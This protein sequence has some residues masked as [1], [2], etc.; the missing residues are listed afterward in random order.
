MIC[1]VQKEAMRN[2]EKIP[3]D[4]ISYHCSQLFS[5]S[6]STPDVE[7]SQGAYDTSSNSVLAPEHENPQSKPIIRKQD[8]RVTGR[9]VN[10]NRMRLPKPMREP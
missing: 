8:K 3:G 10:R 9:Y 2:H 7:E 6:E 5:F 4:S 1:F